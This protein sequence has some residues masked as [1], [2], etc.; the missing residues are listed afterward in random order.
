MLAF[1][2]PVRILL[3]TLASKGP[4]SNRVPPVNI[5]LLASAGIVCHSKRADV[6]PVAQT[7]CDASTQRQASI[8]L[9]D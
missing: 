7:P 1:D 6:S 5:L 3:Q 9:F 4:F 2:L 8:S